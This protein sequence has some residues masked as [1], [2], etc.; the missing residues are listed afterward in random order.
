MQVTNEMVG[1]A[2]LAYMKE[3]AAEDHQV[4][5]WLEPA[6][7]AA[8]TAALSEQERAVEVASLDERMK[9]AGMYTIAEMMGVTP[10]TKWKS[11]PSI[12]TLDAFSEWLDR[13]VREYH[14]MKAGYDLGE[15]SEDDELFEWVEAHAAVYG[16]IRDQFQVV[17]SA[18]VDVPAEPVAWYRDDSFTHRFSLGPSR[19]KNAT[20]NPDE[21][22]PLF[23]STPLSRQGEDSAEVE[24]LTRPI[25]GIEHR[26]AQEVFDIMAD[27]IRLAIAR[28]GSA[29]TAKG[30][31]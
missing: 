21:W 2:M 10:L 31:E 12:N 13:K 8:L 26:T 14:T 25:V 11:N 3:T 19:P 20:Q 6:M 16:T 5:G 23:A 4:S 28:S 7:R 27:R 15:K 22:K 24:R 18:L 29:T 30:G 17:R 9:A 1:M